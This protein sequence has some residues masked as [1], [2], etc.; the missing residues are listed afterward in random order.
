MTYRLALDIGANSIG[1][2]LLDLDAA[3]PPQPR[4]IRG[5]GVRIFP[6]G[7]DPKTSVSLAAARRLARQSRR[8]RDRYL[9][10]RQALLNALIR[11]GLMPAEAAARAAVAALD[12]YALRADA[13]ARRLEPYELGRVV[14]HLNQRRG[15]RSNR[16]TDRDN[17]DEKG[18]LRRAADRLAAEIARSGQQTLGAWLAA[19]HARHADVRARLHG[20]G[21]KAEYPFYSTR[22]MVAAEFDAVW[23]A[24]LQWNP[25]LAPA[26]GDELRTILFFQ[27]DLREPP[28][29]RCWLEP[30]EPRAPRALPSTQAFRIAQD[31]AHLAIRR[32]G[33]PDQPLTDKQ[34]DLLDALMNA[35]RDLSFGQIRK[36]LG[37]VHGETFNLESRA[38]EGLKGSETAARLAGEA[39]GKGKPLGA[40]WSDLDL[41]K[42]D[43][44]A[45]AIQDAESD[46]GAVAAL[47]LLGVPRT[48]AEAVAGTILPEGHA[49]LSTKAMLA[50]LPHLRAGLVYS[51]AVQAAG[52]RH[53]S[54]DRDGVIHPEL[55]YY[56]EVLAERL[57]IGTGKP[58][59]A[60]NP[61]RFFGRAPNPTVHVALNQ[62]RQV[63][64]ALIAQHGHP[65]EVVVEVLRELGQSAFERSRV[66]KEQTANAKRRADWERQLKEIG[67]PVNGR[68]MAFMRL[69]VEQAADP[70]DRVCPYTGERIGI[71]RLFSGEVEEDH[72]LPFALTLDDSFNNR[73]LAMR[74][75]NRRKAR[76]TP[77]DAFGAS[78]EWPAIKARAAAL[79]GGKAWRFAP[80][81]MAKWQ[82]EHG[83]FQARLLTDSAYLSRLAR[84][85]LRAI[86]DPN[87]VWGVP[88]RLTALLRDKL[89]LNSATVLGK[90]GARKERTDH[91][92]HAIDALTVGLIDR[93][94][95]Q[96][97]STA[98]RRAQETGRRLLDNLEEPW[99]GFVAEAAA[100]VRAIV[101]SF[102]PDTAPSGALHN[103]TAYAVVEGAGPREPNMAHRVPVA[104]LAGWKAG[105]VDAAVPDP[106]LRAH[107]RTAL[108]IEGKPAQA[109]ALAQ[110]PHAP[111]V[112]V[113][114]V[115]VRERLDNTAEIADR[116]TGRP[117]KH[118]KLDANHRAE[119]WRLPAKDGKPGKVVMVVVPLM[120]AAM[121]A[122]AK[123]LGRKLVDR[124]PHPAARL[125]MRLHKNDVVA[126]GVGEARRLLRV[127]KFSKGSAMLAPLYEAGNLKARDAD[128]N[129]AFKY[130]NGSITRFR[131]DAARKVQVDPTGR[132]RDP[133]PLH[134]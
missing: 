104:S 35:G 115:Q 130:I 23:A 37:L 50:I 109:A 17:E 108:G 11:N 49:S 67:Q 97:V 100:R 48:A 5:I 16:K 21:A 125:L 82:G 117:Y 46:E 8:R 120:Q 94:L 114:R 59:D 126:L 121:D 128:R 111:G 118:V 40:L 89:A 119:F 44:I 47:E 60:K 26:A 29:G 57:G 107:I 78:P 127:V 51:A 65:A 25:T 83:D 66:E 86:C 134:W 2:C 7:R 113:R 124:R 84:L 10:R 33:E 24:Q 9:Q 31:L 106:R 85:Y 64:N 110:I 36:Q 3:D 101:V 12:P 34:R 27:R 90:G 73:V 41:T 38:R 77:Y 13:L 81:A 18:K 22:E 133:G 105:D 63:V 45:A 98:A 68:N 58:E 123:R 91:R 93:S 15:F 43:A 1:W 52:Y 14:F 88:G 30:T 69:W 53:H 112:S 4:G 99:P 103:D 62:V 87:R 116:R 95:L 92:H 122:E 28:V 54:D 75:A 96:R 39:K 79:P 80:D 102:K 72:I 76:Q 32:V 61:E 132:V 55:P 56:G 19:R 42:R 129:D 70:K 74:E 131:E 6:D 71:E 20:A